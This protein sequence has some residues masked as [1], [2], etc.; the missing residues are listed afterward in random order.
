MP[1]GWH[2]AL[3]AKP[4]LYGVAIAK[5]RA[6]HAVVVASGTFGVHLMGFEHAELMQKLGRSSSR[7]GDKFAKHNIA[8]AQPLALD[9]PLIA[10][11]W[12]AY[13]CRTV[14][15][16]AVGDHDLFV[17]EVMAEHR[18][19]AALDE[20]GLLPPERHPAFY[21]GRSTWTALGPEAPR[22]RFWP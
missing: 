14:A 18:S 13:E 5:G 8:L 9:V 12:L 1:A 16:H 4:P 21:L 17:G 19:E 10:D 22:Q 6:T 3:S 11:A 2:T 7:D 15:V 20:D